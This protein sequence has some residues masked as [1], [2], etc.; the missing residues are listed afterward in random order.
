[1]LV[2]GPF[3]ARAATYHGVARECREVVENAS[4]VG[5]RRW[6]GRLRAWTSNVNTE[7]DQSNSNGVEY[8]PIYDIYVLCT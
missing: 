1:M 8:E 4:I 7:R 2:S 3:F 5:K 6:D